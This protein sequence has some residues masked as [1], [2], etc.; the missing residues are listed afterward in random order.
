MNIVHKLES[1]I[2]KQNIDGVCYGTNIRKL[3]LLEVKKHFTI[4]SDTH[5][6]GLINCTIFGPFKYGLIITADGITWIN[7]SAKNV[8]ENLDWQTLA[9]IKNDIKLV[10]SKIFFGNFGHL[11]MMESRRCSSI[12]A[13]KLFHNLLDFLSYDDKKEIINNKYSNTIYQ[14]DLTSNKE[15]YNNLMPKLI[16]IFIIADGIIAEDQVDL[17]SELIMHEELIDDKEQAFKLIKKTMDEM[18]ECINK[19]FFIFNL[20]IN[21]LINELSTIKSSIHKERLL[22]IIE[23]MA[24]NT[25]G[26]GEM[27]TLDVLDSIKSKLL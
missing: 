21:S 10:G 1:L 19:S 23:G 4:E 18:L 6:M 15:L 25:N 22:I 17:A 20:K 8:K 24:K 27:E 12:D 16:A 2:E 26:F 13:F 5:I 7:Q 14:L 3:K 11:D 9:N